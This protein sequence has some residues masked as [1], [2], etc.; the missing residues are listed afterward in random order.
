MWDFPQLAAKHSIITSTDIVLIALVVSLCVGA[1]FLSISML[2]P[3]LM[4]N[5][6]F[7]AAF[8]LLL[9]AGVLVLIRSINLFNLSTWNL[10]FGILLI[11]ASAFFLIYFVCF[12]K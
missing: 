6:A 9:L 10:V 11:I 1:I 5:L 8:V 2:L 4:V 12:R 3:R 7:V